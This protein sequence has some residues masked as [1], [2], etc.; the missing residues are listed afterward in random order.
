MNRLKKVTLRLFADDVEVLKRA[1]PCEGYNKV[2]RSIVH[3]FAKQ[4]RQK[5]DGQLPPRQ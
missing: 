1:Y 5:I 3:L 4:T 2:I